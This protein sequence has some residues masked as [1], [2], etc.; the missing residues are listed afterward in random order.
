LRDATFTLYALI[1][2][3]YTKEADAWRQWLVN[4]VAAT[5]HKP[6]LTSD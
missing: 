2:G 6:S 4:A 5:F 3:G 1:I